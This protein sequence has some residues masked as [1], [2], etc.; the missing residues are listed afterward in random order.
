LVLDREDN[1]KVTVGYQIKNQYGEDITNSVLPNLE[2]SHVSKGTGTLENGK[3]SLSVDGNEKYSAGVNVTITL[4][5]KTEGLTANATL[6]VVDEA[7]ATEVTFDGI[8]NENGKQL[9]EDTAN[10]LNEDF[11]LLI[12]AVDQ[13][14]DAVN[15]VEHLV[16]DLTVLTS[17]PG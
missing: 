9:T 1:Q 4:V 15:N 8:Y 2:V 7:K 16:E 6:S 11:Y 5:D 17:N 10:E 12:D 3:L 13:Y 14:G